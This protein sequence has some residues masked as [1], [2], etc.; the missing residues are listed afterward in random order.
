VQ[1]QQRERD[2]SYA[3]DRGNNTS[4]GDQPCKGDLGLGGVLFLRD[5]FER[6]ADEPTAIAV[7]YVCP[8]FRKCPWICRHEPVGELPPWNRPNERAAITPTCKTPT[9]TAITHPKRNNPQNLL[10]VESNF[11]E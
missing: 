4:L 8:S 3:N 11:T 10:P 9:P 7:A 1:W 2:A 6:G 5:L